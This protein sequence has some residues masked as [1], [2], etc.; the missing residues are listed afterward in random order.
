MRK[1]KT[2]YS[3]ILSG[4][5]KILFLCLSMIFKI[6]IDIHII[7]N[8]KSSLKNDSTVVIHSALV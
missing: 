1:V 2:F 5:T 6:Y 7:A 3:L 8:L 4:V